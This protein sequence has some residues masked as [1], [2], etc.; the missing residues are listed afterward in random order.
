MR[1]QDACDGWD[2]KD[3][4]ERGPGSGG[5]RRSCGVRTTLFSSSFNCTGS[6]KRGQAAVRL[7]PVVVHAFEELASDRITRG[8]ADHRVYRASWAD[9]GLALVQPLCN[10]RRWGDCGAVEAAANGA[11]FKLGPIAA[12]MLVGAY[13]VRLWAWS[14]HE[15]D[16]SW[17]KNSSIK[18]AATA[19]R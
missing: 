5:W 6:V 1:I 8:G 12:A 16:T 15:L 17:V 10:F 13:V 14:Q 9:G 4:V 7:K 18:F 3:R 2:D 19:A 11:G